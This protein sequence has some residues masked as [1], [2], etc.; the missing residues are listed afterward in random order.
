MEDRYY[1]KMYSVREFYIFVREALQTIKYMTRSRK[2]GLID[3][4]FRERIML[5]VTEVNGCQICSYAH[6]GNALKQG[7]SEK[8][9]SQIL[10]GSIDNVP[11][12]EA[13][14]IIFAQ[15]YA[16]N[17]GR[18]TKAAWNRLVELY[19]IDKAYGVLAFTRVIMMGNI[20]GIGASAFL[21][22]IKGN[23]IGKSSLFYELAIMISGI[24]YVPIA[25]LRIIVMSK[26]EKMR[27]R[28]FNTGMNN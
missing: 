23:P 6:T 4:P 8:E 2:E 19:G 14:G 7:M 12:D 10:L 27:I 18:P 9:I 26:K 3:A 1:K 13:A 22:R 25:F 20:H 16:N 24:L 28:F 11:E 5:A 17:S 15:H 21:S